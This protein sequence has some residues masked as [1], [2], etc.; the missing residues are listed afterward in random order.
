MIE[1]E[2]KNKT[3]NE[4]LENI[5]EQII[6]NQPYEKMYFNI[7]RYV[8]ALLLLNQAQHPWHPLLFLFL[9]CKS[10]HS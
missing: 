5:F 4:K 2:K 9:Q 3:I 1:D 8:R 7:D 6:Y 10:F